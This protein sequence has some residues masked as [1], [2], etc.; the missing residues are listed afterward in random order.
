[1]RIKDII[2]ESQINPGIKTILQQKGYKLLGN[3]VDQQAYLEPRTGLVL[4]IFGRSEQ[5]SKGQEAFFE[6]AR[7]CQSHPN[8]Q[9]LPQI[10]GWQ[11][12][13]FKGH[14]YLQIR[15]ERMFA[16]DDDLGEALS[17]FA[18]A[19]CS[20]RGN[21]DNY[22]NS[23]A[24]KQADS[25]GDN[26]GRKVHAELFTHV[27]EQGLKELWNTIVQLNAIAKRHPDLSMDLHGGNFMY[28]S[29]GHIVIS[30][31]FVSSYS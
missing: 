9:F 27:G 7:F 15:V 22:I 3:G 25:W 24:A 2:A 29:D 28:G 20:G 8:N 19:A 23:H 18:M 30:D 5:K 1:M 21:L 14:R 17:D 13:N 26:P 10:S 12:F 6:F 16:I 11:T 31:P 4:K